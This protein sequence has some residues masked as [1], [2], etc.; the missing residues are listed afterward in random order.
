MI[1][2]R[3]ESPEAEEKVAEGARNTFPALP[4]VAHTMLI[5]LADGDQAVIPAAAF[6]QHFVLGNAAGEDHGVH[7]E[8]LDPEM[9]VE[10]MNREDETRREQGFIGMDQSGRC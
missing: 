8:F 4:F 9:R 3:T 2:T 1:K 6:V 5:Q 10:E 7:R